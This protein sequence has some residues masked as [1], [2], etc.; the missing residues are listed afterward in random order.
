MNKKR[1]STIFL[2]L[3]LLFLVFGLSADNTLYTW[4]SI[5][6]VLLSLILGGRW[7]RPRRK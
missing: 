7:M 5:V 1:W 4:I 3:G 2:A 6:F